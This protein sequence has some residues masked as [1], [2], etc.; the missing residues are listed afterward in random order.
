MIINLTNYKN[1]NAFTLIEV[2]VSLGIIAVL[3]TFVVLNYHSINKRNNLTMTSA[4]ILSDF[5]LAQSYSLGSRSYGDVL[6]L[7][8]W[9][10]YFDLNTASSYQFFA[11]LNGNGQYDLGEGENTQGA[12][13]KDFPQD[14]TL[15]A[16][17][18]AQ[19]INVTFS[20][21]IPK[22]VIFDGLNTYSNCAISFREAISGAIKTIEVNQLGLVESN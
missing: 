10:L 8:G 19:S 5:R 4:K 9:G 12:F 18:V 3:S 17:D 20:P 2:I 14:I 21:L 6:P 13:I 7:G 15:N 1:K 16:I 11:D 22:A